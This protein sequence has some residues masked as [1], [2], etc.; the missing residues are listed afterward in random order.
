[1]KNFV[2]VISLALAASN[3]FSQDCSKFIFMKQGRTME[4]TTYNGSG[5]V[6]HKVIETVASAT[7]SGG[8]TTANVTAQNFDQNSNPRSKANISYKCDNGT[9]LIDVS[10]M[11]PQQGNFQFSSAL[12]PYPSTLTVGQNFPGATLTMTMNMGNKTMTTKVDIT[13]RTVVDK[14]SLTTPAGTWECYK[15]TYKL[16]TTM[17]GMNIPP[18]TSM[19]TEWYVPG[20]A[21]I[22]WQMGAMTTKLTAVSG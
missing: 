14:E 9:L 10:S 16:T 17:Q 20:Y 2:L 7:T 3:L 22:Q 21:I 19:V 8:V 13:D 1:M 15:M 4:M 11:M 6:M 18:S 12:M 5:K